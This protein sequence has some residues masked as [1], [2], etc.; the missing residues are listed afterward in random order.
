MIRGKTCFR[1]YKE[2]QKLLKH[3]LDYIP[4]GKYCHNENGICPFWTIDYMKM[5]QEQGNGF[6]YFLNKGDCE[7]NGTLFLWNGIKECCQNCDILD[8][9]F[10]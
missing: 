5:D 3:A 10:E 7:E 2:I 8:E 4:K 6:C 1:S 9:E